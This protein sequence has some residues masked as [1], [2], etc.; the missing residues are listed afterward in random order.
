M[1]ALIAPNC[2]ERGAYAAE[3]KSSSRLTDTYKS[4]EGRLRV[5]L[6]PEHGEPAM[7]VHPYTQAG[8]MRAVP[9]IKRSGQVIG[10]G[11]LQCQPTF[12]Q[13]SLPCA[14]LGMILGGRADQVSSLGHH[15]GHMTAGVAIERLH[16]DR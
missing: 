11:S 8:E 7:G 13:Q 1:S 4:A 2:V 16:D 3:V 14:D 6:R 10:A 15:P 5:E 12:P 9:P